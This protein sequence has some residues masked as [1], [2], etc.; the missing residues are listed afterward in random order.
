MSF[1]IVVSFKEGV[2]DA[3]GE[4]VKSSV[5]DDLGIIVNS[6]ETADVYEVEGISSSDISKITELV[7]DPV[8]QAVSEAEQENGWL[9]EVGFLN[10]VTDNAAETTRQAIKDIVRKDVSVRTSKLYC[11][12]GAR[13][14]EI[15]RIC[16]SL[17]YNKLIQ[18]CKVKDKN[19]L[20]NNTFSVREDPKD[21]KP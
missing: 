4:G 10:G 16:N 20:H 3:L 1:R 6:V 11:I 17:L 5:M 18:F 12:K 2:K 13:K 9:I 7:A 15:A 19:K 21:E 14:D 8:V